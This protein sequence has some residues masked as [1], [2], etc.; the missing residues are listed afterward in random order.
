MQMMK[1]MSK[2][3]IRAKKRGEDSFARAFNPI[4]NPL[5]R[6]R[7]VGEAELCGVKVTPEDAKALDRL[8]ANWTPEETCQQ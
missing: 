3:R 5:R 6:G 4:H 7:L 1:S 2:A 8:D